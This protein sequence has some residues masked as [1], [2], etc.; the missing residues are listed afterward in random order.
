MSDEVAIR[1]AI[2]LLALLSP[3]IFS[4]TVAKKPSSPK[5][6]HPGSRNMSNQ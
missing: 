2:V 1:V 4:K 3:V 5:Q 6:K